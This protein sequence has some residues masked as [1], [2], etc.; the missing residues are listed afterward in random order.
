V[1]KETLD[2]DPWSASRLSWID[3]H[4][5]SFSTPSDRIVGY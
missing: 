2:K 5:V 4:T 3:F 1:L